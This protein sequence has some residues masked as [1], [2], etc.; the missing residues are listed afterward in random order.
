MLGKI[1]TSL[2]FLKLNPSYSAL[3]LWLDSP[4]FL[5]ESD[6]PAKPTPVSSFATEDF[7]DTWASLPVLL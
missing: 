3:H 2:A 4:Q 5:V 1:K 6:S 7:A